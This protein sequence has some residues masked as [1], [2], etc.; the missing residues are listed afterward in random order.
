MYQTQKNQ[1]RGLSKGEF[2]ALRELCRLS[3]NM[4]N[5]GLYETRQH[6]FAERQHLR[7]ESIYH[8]AKENENYK[9]LQTDV[10][11]QTL[12]IV[13]RSFQSFFGLWTKKQEGVY[14]QQVNLPRYLPK[15][16]YFLLVFTRIR[17]KDGYWFIPMSPAF[18]KQYGKVKIPFPKRLEG[19]KIKEIRIHPRYQARFFEVEYIVEIEPEIHQL[20]PVKALSID[21]GLDNLA[22]CV[23]TDGASFI[24]DGKKLKSINQWY[25]KE[26][27][28]LQSIKNKQG[29]KGFTK[30]QAR[31]TI[32]RNNQ[33]R[34]FLSKS[35]RHIINYCLAKSISKLV[36][37]SNPGW[38]QEINLGRKTNQKFVQIPFYSLKQK[39][40]S[41]CERYGITYLGQEESYTSKASFLD[42]DKIP[43][44]N[45]DKPKEYAFSGKRI[46]RG[47]YRSKDSLVINADI[48]G[49]ANILRKSNHNFSRERV[50]R[51]LLL[52][53]P[54][55]ISSLR[56]L[57]HANAWAG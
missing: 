41:L 15:E 29:I 42:N 23:D 38:K 47:L 27:A 40:K 9:L 28:R 18:K 22:S 33:V 25:N 55:R 8:R 52:N 31:I 17:V 32:N 48:N 30:R 19:K 46:K 54:L 4:F 14:F 50:A 10:A 1:I 45:A 16:G 36:V 7:Y 43:I 3:K 5:V 44:Y 34:D 13:D 12:K 11:Q 56:I 26:N 49:S 51:G 6:F 2:T 53:R 35:A 21:L 57:V 39:L 20:D 24:L 37:G